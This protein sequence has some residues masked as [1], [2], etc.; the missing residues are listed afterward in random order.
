MSAQLR[1]ES[2]QKSVQYH[3]LE[4]NPS[5]FDFRKSRFLNLLL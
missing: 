1:T 5:D 4:E 2:N 3:V